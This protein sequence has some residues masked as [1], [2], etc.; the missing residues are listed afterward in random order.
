[1]S[2]LDHPVG[3]VLTHD[4]RYAY[5]SEQAAGGGQVSRFDLIAGGTRV[6]VATGFTAPFFLTWSDASE[7][8]L[9]VT[10]RD[11]ANKVV[12]IDLTATPGTVT[13]LAANVP[14]RPSCVAVLTP[15]RLVFTSD[16]VV[17]DLHLLEY[18]A[19]GPMLLG[20]GFVPFNKI[21]GGL[22]TTDPGYFFQV[23]QAPFGGRL[24]LMVNHPRAYQRGVRF[25]K[26]LVDGVE[27]H[28]TWTDY[29]LNGS[30]NFVL[31]TIS[32]VS[33]NF[34]AIRSP[35]QTWYNPY[36]GFFVNSLG[37]SNGLHTITLQLYGSLAGPAIGH[38][39]LVVLVDNNRCSASLAAPL[40]NGTPADADCGVLN[41][42]RDGSG[43]PAGALTLAFTAAHPNN[44]AT[45]S[46]SL[47]RGVTPV[48]LVARSGAVST[49]VS[50]I[51]PAPTAQDLL[52]TCAI[53]GFAESVYVAATAI[54]GWSRQSQYDASAQIAFVLAPVGCGS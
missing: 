6:T 23:R 51:A 33:G 25:Y 4:G 27:Q 28:E 35:S 2:G 43:N 9:Y 19:T 39:D 10:D 44:Y 7:T 41:Y 21:V 36:L 42:T 47:L 31:Q 15:D 3:V 16:S 5:I 1:V 11:P 52:G 13:T 8:L 46:F 17:S 32:N 53:A 38:Q 37:V 45:Y 50:P 48:G 14:F 30:G 22:A 24:P 26:V 18:S 29:L 34:Y 40:L 54:D 49:V 20:I 12:A